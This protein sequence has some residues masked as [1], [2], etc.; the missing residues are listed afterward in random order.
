MGKWFSSQNFWLKSFKKVEKLSLMHNCWMFLCTI[1]FVKVIK[2]ALNNYPWPS[3]QCNL[4]HNYPRCTLPDP[5]G[6]CPMYCKSIFWKEKFYCIAVSQLLHPTFIYIGSQAFICWTGLDGN[7]CG[8]LLYE[9]HCKKNIKQM[10][11]CIRKYSNIQIYS[12]Q[13]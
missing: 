9:H 1:I 13:W 4:M 2:V 12:Y 11:I 10:N 7:L 3:V 8:H 6:L 5:T